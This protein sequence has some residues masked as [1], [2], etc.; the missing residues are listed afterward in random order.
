MKLG[1]KIF[2][3]CAGMVMLGVASVGTVAGFGMLLMRE[4]VVEENKQLGLTAGEISSGSMTA[5][6]QNNLQSMADERADEANDNFLALQRLVRITT[7]EMTCLYENEEDYAPHDVK[8][9]VK[10]NAGEISVQM[11]H[12]ADTDMEDPEII[13]EAA[14]VGNIDDTLYSIHKNAPNIAANYIATKSGITI[15]ADRIA[16][17]KFGEDGEVMPFEASQRPW[18]QGAMETQN[19]YFTDVVQD[20]HTGVDA[21]MCAAPFYKGEECMGIAGAGMYLSD[22]RDVVLEA[23]VGQEGYACII[24]GDGHILFSTSNQGI[25]TM[26]EDGDTPDVRTTTDG[27]LKRAL[28]AACEGKRGVSP[29]IFRDVNYYVAYSPIETMGWSFFTVINRD[30]VL[31][32]TVRICEAIDETEQQ[33]TEGIDEYIVGIFILFCLMGIIIFV[34]LLLAAGWLSGRVVKPIKRLTKC[35]KEIEGD[36]LAFKWE[37]KTHDETSILAEAFVQMTDKMRRYIEDITKITAEKERI[38]AELDVAAKIQADMLPK[39]FPPFPERSE[40]DIYATMEPAKEVG[41]DFYDFFLIDEDHLGIV[42]ADVSSKGVP[43][44]LFMM[45]SK[46]LIKNHAMDGESLNDVFYTVNNQLCEGNEEGMFVTAWMAVLTISTGQL[47]YINAG[48]NPQLMS[49]D[50]KFDWIVAEP[51]FVLAGIEGIRYKSCVGQ[52]QH[53]EKLFLYTD[54]LSEAQNAAGELYGEKRLIESLNRHFSLPL[55]EMMQAVRA[56]IDAFVGDA[57]QFD[58]MTMVVLEYQ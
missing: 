31:S 38:G 14:L 3:T 10:E 7:D 22:L 18:Y 46:T 4:I 24:N 30:K 16:N 1:K 52:M 36:H 27:E 20:A 35:V 2:L 34:L 26:E 25:L 51:E 17:Q 5:Q 28:E 33:I 37:Y 8:E 42:I 32:P 40:F 44:A 6:I 50:G 57:E 49:V 58:D 12:S 48:H 41:G 15:L 43:A 54:G 53:G 29:V 23:N 56:D 9:P 13:R 47:E 21:V 55:K 11:L 45:I 19:A 39:I